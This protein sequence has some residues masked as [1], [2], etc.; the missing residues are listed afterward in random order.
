[1]GTLSW[2]KQDV[3]FYFFSVPWHLNPDQVPI[4]D[5]PLNPTPVDVVT[6][7]HG[8]LARLTVL[9]LQLLQVSAVVFPPEKHITFFE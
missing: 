3:V 5:F 9:S 4:E 8:R 1:M 7:L 2:F 6:K